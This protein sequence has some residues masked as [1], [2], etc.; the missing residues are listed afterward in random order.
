M[1][2]DP[3]FIREILRNPPFLIQFHRRYSHTSLIQDYRR[4]FFTLSEIEKA[5]SPGPSDFQTPS[6]PSHADVERRALDS[7]TK[8]QCSHGRCQVSRHLNSLSPSISPNA[9]SEN[10]RLNRLTP[11]T[12]PLVPCSPTPSLPSSPAT[13]N[14]TRRVSLIPLLSASPPSAFHLTSPS[15]AFTRPDPNNGNVPHGLD[16]NT[17]LSS[18]TGS[19]VGLHENHT[20]KCI[21]DKQP[22]RVE[23]MRIVATF[24]QPGA[25]KEL[26]LDGIIRDTVVRD[27]T[28]STHPDVFLTAYEEIYQMIE[29]TSL[30]RFLAFSTTN[31]NRPK[32]LFWYLCGVLFLLTSVAS[33]VA[34]ITMVPDSNSSNRAWRLFALPWAWLGS[35]QIYAASMGFC[36]QVWSRNGVQLHAWELSEADEESKLFV[37]KIISNATHDGSSDRHAPHTTLVI[38]PHSRPNVHT[39]P[40]SR[41]SCHTDSTVN[42]TTNNVS[43]SVTHSEPWASQSHEF[44][45]PLTPYPLPP[46]GAT[47]TLDSQTVSVVAPFLSLDHEDDKTSDQKAPS[48]E[49]REVYPESHH[50]TLACPPIFGPERV[51]QDARIKAAHGRVMNSIWLVGFVYVLVFSA[52]IFSVPSRIRS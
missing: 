36:N 8:L 27:L 40:R 7:F 31:I 34:I 35:M 30:P 10:V 12:T 20:S 24:L 6:S 4:R 41:S 32:Q 13:P 21:H 52:V 46:R 25:V 26:P 48:R 16:H 3:A 19:H 5:Y 18:Q 33:A 50:G 1:A 49:I 37:E 39:Q 28:S 22:F 15:V 23:C 45:E 9:R 11:L 14:T 42:A 2:F 38:T 29:H 43:S 17:L 44:D 47:S 51:V